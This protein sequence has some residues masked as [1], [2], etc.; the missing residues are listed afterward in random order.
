MFANSWHNNIIYITTDWIHLG[1]WCSL[2]QILKYH[3]GC[4]LL[5][6]RQYKGIC[7]GTV[8]IYSMNM[9]FLII[10][11]SERKSALR[12]ASRTNIPVL[13][14]WEEIYDSKR[15]SNNF[16]CTLRSRG[17]LYLEKGFEQLSS[18]PVVLDWGKICTSKSVANNY[19]C[20]LHIYLDGRYTSNVVQ[21]SYSW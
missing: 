12:K 8:K 17:N 2:I 1:M 5:V 4:W 10:R 6:S 3:T 13:L 21:W 9:M 19:P 15:V 14:D 18:I 20:R 7:L 11:K 16:P